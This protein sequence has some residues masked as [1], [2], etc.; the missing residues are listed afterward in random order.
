[1]KSYSF[2]LTLTCPLQER[3]LF[4]YR[5][6]IRLRDVR[7]AWKGRRDIW[8]PNLVRCWV[9]LPHVVGA[10]LLELLDTAVPDVFKG[11]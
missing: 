5:E 8:V 3:S 4:R 10:H 2:A 6:K 11:R 1:M 9:E 7:K